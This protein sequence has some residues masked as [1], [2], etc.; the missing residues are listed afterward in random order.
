M[1]RQ[2]VKILRGAKPADLP[3]EQP[4]ILELTVSLASQLTAFTSFIGGV[5]PN[6]GSEAFRFID[7]VGVQYLIETETEAPL[8]FKKCL[9]PRRAV[10]DGIQDVGIVI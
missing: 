7:C 4:T 8:G 5:G 10:G 6:A 1:T 9:E 2:V 3:I